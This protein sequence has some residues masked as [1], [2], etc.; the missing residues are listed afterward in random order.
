MVF[1]FC[2]A[3][4]LVV[5]G[6]LSSV[7]SSV[8]KLVYIFTQ[9]AYW[10]VAAPICLLGVFTFNESLA[11]LWVFLALFTMLIMPITFMLL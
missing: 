5:S 1:V 3:I 9:N 10:I 7:G 6:A 8:N 11:M 4:N 2:L